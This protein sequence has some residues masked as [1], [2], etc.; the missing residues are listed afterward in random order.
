MTKLY[1]L[2]GSMK[3]LESLDLDSETL[4]DTIEA[5]TGE[6]NDKAV[7]ILSFTENMS[8]DIDKLSAE[9]KRLQARKSVFE[10]RKKR[11]REYLL[12]NMESS[13]ITKIECPYFTASIRKGVESVCIDDQELIPDDYITMEVTE[14][15]DKAAIK[16]DLKAGNQ[17]S[18][19][20]LKRCANTITIK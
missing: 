12:Y 13:G 2:T 16:R 20:S 11:L 7:A 10:N 19:V 14:K 1:E 8:G 4:S 9:I 3:D 18:G 6:F 15:V 17:I 5:V